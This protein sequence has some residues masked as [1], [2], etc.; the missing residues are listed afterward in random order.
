[1]TS[2]SVIRLGSWAPVASRGM[3]ID[4]AAEL[5]DRMYE[6]PFDLL[7]HLILAEEVDIHE[8]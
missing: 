8:V 3:A 7:L 6:G 5:P 1:M 4:V 2:A